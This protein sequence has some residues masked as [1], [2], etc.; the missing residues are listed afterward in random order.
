[1]LDLRLGESDEVRVYAAAATVSF[2]L[3][4]VESL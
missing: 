4:G 3:F 2:S 1:V